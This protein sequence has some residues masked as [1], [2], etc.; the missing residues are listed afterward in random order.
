V[1]GFF[2]VK[3]EAVGPGVRPLISALIVVLSSTSGIW[4]LCY[5]NLLTSSV[6]ALYLFA[7]S[8][9]GLM[10]QLLCHGTSEMLAW[11]LSWGRPSCRLNAVVVENT[12]SELDLRR[13]WWKIWLVQHHLLLLNSQLIHISWEIV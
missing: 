9:T 1:F 2:H 6:M 13:Q 5:M 12:S 3:C 11:N 10:T 7:C 4:D 8:Y